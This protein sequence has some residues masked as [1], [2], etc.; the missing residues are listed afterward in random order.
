MSFLSELR[1]K[2]ITT[3]VIITSVSKCP[4]SRSFTV[5]RAYGALNV[6]L[7]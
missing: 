2:V 7:V 4:L 5:T 6:T 3:F 1:P